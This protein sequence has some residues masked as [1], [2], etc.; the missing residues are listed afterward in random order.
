MHPY[1]SKMR[2]AASKKEKKEVQST[3]M[4]DVVEVYT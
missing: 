2:T 4:G 1:C 3:D